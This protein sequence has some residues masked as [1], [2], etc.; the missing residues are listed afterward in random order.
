MSN[1]DSTSGVLCLRCDA[2]LGPH[3]EVC[4]ACGASRIVCGRFRITRL[5]GRGGMGRIYEADTQLGGERVAVKVLSL[6]TSTDWLLRDLF[7]RSTRVLMGLA[8]PALPKVYAF[9]QDDTGRFV[10]VRD[11]FDGGTLLERIVR[12]DRRL[13]P[14]EV[15]RLLEALLDLLV[16]LQSRVPA[17]IHRDIKPSNV[18]FRRDGDDAPVLVDF[19]TVAAPEGRRSGMTIVGTP[20]YT[21]PEQFAGEA[22]PSTDVYSLGATMLFVVTHVEADN[23]PRVGGRFDVAKDLASLDPA[24]RR[25][26]L[27]MV[28]IDREKRYATAALALEDLRREDAA[29]PPSVRADA[30]PSSSQLPLNRQNRLAILGVIVFACLPAAIGVMVTHRRTTAPLA[31]VATVPSTPTAT[32]TAT[33]KKA[34][35]YS[36]C[37]KGDFEGCTAKCQKG[38]TQSCGSLGLLYEAGTVVGKD[39]T[40]AAG[41]YGQACEGGYPPSCAKLGFLTQM[42]TGTP[43]DLARAV[44]LYARACTAVET[45]GCDNLG[46][47]YRNGMGVEKDE[48]RSVALFQQ[49]CDAGY[50]KG[51]VD[52]GYN[53]ETGKGV[54]KDLS[55]AVTLYARGCT[56]KEARGCG[57]LGWLY[58]QGLGVDKDVVRSAT[59]SSQGCDGNDMQSCNN[60]GTMYATGK[61]VAKD[62]PRAFA[63]YDRACTAGNMQACSNLAWTYWNGAGVKKDE[64]RA[65]TLFKQACDGGHA[66][67]CVSLGLHYEKGTGVAKDLAR[68]VALYKQACDAGNGGGC[69]NLGNLYANG[70]GVTKDYDR[71]AALARQGCDGNSATGCSN[72]GF[73]VEKGHSGPAD[74]TQAVALYRQGCKGGN[75]WGCAQLKR[76]GEAP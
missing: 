43:K 3:D 67:A 16:Y 62:E 9:E 7:E 69:S 17:V 37:N 6:G 23:L 39:L 27:R 21:A 51:C 8:H 60:L 20:G 44:E 32:A 19:D 54:P 18:M 13:A 55:R 29:P 45:N 71:A 72:L 49:S 41:L 38:D 1:S 24:T 25:V 34:V 64:A 5:L 65:I 76:L 40:R 26:L 36:G 4:R 47:M 53:Y 15:R 61:G 31:P 75:D 12:D 11:A 66:G 30:A 58:G 42:G 35:V 2:T 59:L 57:N 56:G 50:L 52:L 70:T 33:A 73:I 63:L 10:L 22:T 46:F 74:R 68:A 48:A 14:H 28:E